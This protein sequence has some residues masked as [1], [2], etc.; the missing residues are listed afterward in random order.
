MLVIYDSSYIR[1]SLIVDIQLLT[2]LNIVFSIQILWILKPSFL[3]HKL[4]NSLIPYYILDQSA[5]CGIIK[6]QPK[7]GILNHSVYFVFWPIYITFL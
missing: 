5:L 3:N 6:D 7:S 1:T 4:F 2:C